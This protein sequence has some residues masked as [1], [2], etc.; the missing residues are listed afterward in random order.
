MIPC[1]PFISGVITL[2]KL[3]MI[4]RPAIRGTLEL[5]RQSSNVIGHWVKVVTPDIKGPLG[6]IFNILVCVK[7][8]RAYFGKNIFLKKLSFISQNRILGQNSGVFSF[9]PSIISPPKHFF[10]F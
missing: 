10:I 8:Y 7:F 1:G 3:P 2:R 9:Q 6:I 4:S 5:R